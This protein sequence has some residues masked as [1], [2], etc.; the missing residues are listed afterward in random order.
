MQLYWSL[1]ERTSD[2]V[3]IDDVDTVD[4]FCVALI[5]GDLD[6][7]RRAVFFRS[8]VSTIDHDS[9]CGDI[10]IGGRLAVFCAVE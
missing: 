2:L 1:R 3:R 4:I 7:T 5:A 6:T 8:Q 9:G 10:I